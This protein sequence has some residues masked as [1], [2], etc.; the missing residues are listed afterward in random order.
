MPFDMVV[1]DMVVV[2][3]VV[4]DMVVVDQALEFATD[5]VGFMDP[6]H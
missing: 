4:V 1:V 5:S 3:M 6:M 2:D